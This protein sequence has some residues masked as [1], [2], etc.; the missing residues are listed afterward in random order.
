[1][2]NMTNPMFDNVEFKESLNN[3]D[4]LFLSDLD[5]QANV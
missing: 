5:R 3:T 1:M 2:L 4:D